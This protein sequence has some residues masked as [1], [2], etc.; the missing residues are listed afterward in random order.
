MSDCDPGD[1]SA[2]GLPVL[3][4][5]LE[6]AQINVHWVSDVIKSFNAL[7]PSY[8]PALKLS[9]YQWVGWSYQV[10]K[11][12]DL[13]LQS[14][15]WI[16]RVDFLQDWLVQSPC[17]PRDSQESSPT[18][19]LKSTYYLVLSLLYGPT[20]TSTHYYWKNHSFNRIFVC[21]AMFLLFNTLS[22]FVIA[23]LP[24][25]KCLSLSL[26]LSPSAMIH[27]CHCF[28]CFPIYL[29][30]SDGI[31]CHDLSFLTLSFI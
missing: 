10:S 16:F 11:L 8:P 24:R 2:P 17:S 4:Y 1:C 29:P 22:R 7:L 15:Q 25:S 20:I 6:F 26:L 3:H 28:H 13:Q 14:F 31:T 23:F 21:Q 27:V 5:L 19:Q 12:L 18:P 30:W 9:Q